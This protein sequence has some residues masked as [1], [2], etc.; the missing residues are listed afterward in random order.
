MMQLTTRMKHRRAW[1]GRV[2]SSAFSESTS[3][4]ARSVRHPEDHRR[5]RRAGGD[6]QD[7]HASG[8]AC[9]RAAARSGAAA[10]A[11]SG[12]LILKVTMVL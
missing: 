6:C 2:C 11:L 7:T 3:N 4:T 8:L 9:A 1:A 5:H 12:G 10:V